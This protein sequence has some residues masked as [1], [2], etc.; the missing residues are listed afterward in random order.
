MNPMTNR[1]PPNR[2]TLPITVP[3]DLLE[4]LHPG[5]HSLWRLPLELDEARTVGRPSDGGGASSNHHSGATSDH[6]SQL[7]EGADQRRIELVKAVG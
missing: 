7:D 6:R 5:S 4:L 2:E 1:Q 3:S